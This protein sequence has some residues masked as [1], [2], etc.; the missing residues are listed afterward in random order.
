MKSRVAVVR[1]ASLRQKGAHMTE[2]TVNVTL[3]VAAVIALVVVLL[4]SH[5]KK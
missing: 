5:K 3:D 2:M 4:L 1:A